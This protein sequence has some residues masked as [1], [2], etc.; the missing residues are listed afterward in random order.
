M[1]KFNSSKTAIGFI[2]ETKPIKKI[3]FCPSKAHRLAVL[4]ENSTQVN[5]Y[6]L[7]ER[8]DSIYKDTVQ[9]KHMLYC[10]KMYSS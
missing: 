2:E 1:R 8:N 5:V 3:Q 4:T 10:R 6:R 9:C 7:E